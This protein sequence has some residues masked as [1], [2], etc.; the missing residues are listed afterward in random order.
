MANYNLNL[1]NSDMS[2]AYSDCNLSINLDSKGNFSSG[3][4]AI[5]LENSDLETITLQPRD[6]SSQSTWSSF[7]APYTVQSFDCLG[8]QESGEL[9]SITFWFADVDLT[10]TDGTTTE[11]MTGF[12]QF[13]MDQGH[14]FQN[15][16]AVAFP[17]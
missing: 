11:M 9:L 4:I 15:Y 1:Y 2:I 17:D 16:Y 8:Q 5:L 3:S 10:N 13:S 7:M 6:P 12:C 14:T